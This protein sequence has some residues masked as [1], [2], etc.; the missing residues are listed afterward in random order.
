MGKGWRFTR[1]I[2]K[3]FTSKDRKWCES[4]R[5]LDG[6][7]VIVTGANAGLGKETVYQL[8]MRGANV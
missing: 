2:Y 3:D 1:Y 8:A 4:K 5:R 6:K 7:V